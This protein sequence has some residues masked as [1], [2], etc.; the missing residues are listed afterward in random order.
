MHM[1]VLVLNRIELDGLYLNFVLCLVFKE[2][3]NRMN[4]SGILQGPAL[5]G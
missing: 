5:T 1:F 2:E 3:Y 4:G